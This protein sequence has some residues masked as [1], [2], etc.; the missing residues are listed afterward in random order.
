MSTEHND[1]SEKQ[2]LETCNKAP[3]L[4]MQP[5]KSLPFSRRGTR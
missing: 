2:L 3:G 5:H 4:D 1:S